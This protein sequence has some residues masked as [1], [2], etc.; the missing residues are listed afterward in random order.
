MPG[1]RSLSF[2]MMQKPVVQKPVIA[3]AAAT[4]QSHGR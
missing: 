2:A 1:D 3:S 4:Q